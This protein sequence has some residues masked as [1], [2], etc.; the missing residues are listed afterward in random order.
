MLNKG[1]INLTTLRENAINIKSKLKPCVKFC[2]VVKADAYGHGAE[3]ISNAIYD[4]ADCF[5]VALP[6]EGVKLRQSGIKKDILVLTPIIKKDAETVIQYNLTACI[7]T[8]SVLKHLERVAKKNR[9]TAKVHIAINTGMNRFGIDDITLLEEMFN[10]AKDRKNIFIEGIFSHFYNPQDKVALKEQLKKFLLAKK[11][12]I[13]YN[14]NTVC[15]LSASGGLLCGVQFNMVR[16]GILLYGYKPFK[17]NAISVKPILKVYTHVIEKRN[18][19]KGDNVLYGDFPAKMDEEYC[20]L[21]LG[22]ADGL[23]RKSVSHQINNMCMDTSAFCLSGKIG[24][25]FIL[26]D[27]DVLAKSYGTI[28]YEIL[29]KITLRLEKEY[30][31]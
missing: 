25:K 23:M 14:K 24:K 3:I 18:V 29:T 10:Y 4:L 7:D 17:S 19:K 9:T 16:V 8:F 22:Y 31:R 6:E 30:I 26:P 11:V 27:A 13:C 21:R 15:H 28:S 5:A 20:L 12:A 1:V 2:A